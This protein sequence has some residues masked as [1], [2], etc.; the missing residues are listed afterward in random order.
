MQMAGSNNDFVDT[1]FPALREAGSFIHFLDLQ[2]M[3]HAKG[4]H[5]AWPFERGS[6]ARRIDPLQR[7]T[8]IEGQIGLH[9]VVRLVAARRY[10]GIAR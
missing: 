3:Q 9:V 8:E 6:G 1:L 7:N 2:A 5:A 4:R 10:Q